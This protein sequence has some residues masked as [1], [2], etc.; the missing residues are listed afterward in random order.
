M[1]TEIKNPLFELKSYHFGLLVTIILVVI[2]RLEHFSAPFE[3]DEGTYAYFASLLLD[4]ALPYDA[5]YDTKPAGLFYAYALLIWIFGGTSTDLHF[6]FL[7]VNLINLLI[8]Y[9]LITKLLNQR[10][11]S[12]GALA[13]GLVALN[14]FMGGL[15]ILSEHLLILFAS[16]GMLALS[17]L[18]ERNYLKLSLAAGCCM[19]LS[20]FLKQNGLFFAAAGGLYLI[21]WTYLHLKSHYASIIKTIIGYGFMVLIPTFLIFVYLSVQGLGKEFI[22]WHYTYSVKYIHDVGFHEGLGYLTLTGTNIMDGHMLW[23]L[24]AVMGLVFLFKSKINTMARVLILIFLPMSLI[25]ITPRWIFHGHYFLFLL[26]IVA[27]LVAYGFQWLHTLVT[28]THKTRF[29]L[30]VFIGAFTVLVMT[31]LSLNR[32]YLFDPDYELLMRRWYGSNPFF[33]TQKVAEKINTLSNEGDQLG[34]FGAEMQLYHYTGLK[35]PTKHLYGPYLVDGSMEHKQR[36]EEYIE[37]LEN[38]PPRFFVAV[39]HPL[40]WVIKDNADRS[41]FHWYGTF[42]QKNYELIGLVDIEFG[43]PSV[44]HWGKNLGEL[45][46]KGKHQVFVWE[47]KK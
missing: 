24:L 15:S 21:F 40:T 22:Y 46:L 13:F 44:F 14:P 41:I 2:F 3:R 34:V 45:P 47:L 33:E 31:H 7:V 5:F 1:S 32:A 26:P 39:H 29:S 17:H 12:I 6:A 19:G 20:I 27:V 11:A 8:V 23:F 42:T 36:Q 43:R 35:A 30:Y 25:S 38:N 9:L 10:S 28:S 4:G 37:D 18:T 16:A